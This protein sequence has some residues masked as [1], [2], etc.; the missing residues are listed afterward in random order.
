MNDRIMPDFTFFL[1]YILFPNP[2]RYTC[3]Q[4]IIN[5]VNPM[6]P[7][8]AV[9]YVMITKIIDKILSVVKVISMGEPKMS[10]ILKYANSRAITMKTTTPIKPFLLFLY[11]VLTLAIL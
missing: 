9:E 8:I 10:C 11:D 1:P 2:T 3:K 4:P 7:P 6:P 5:I